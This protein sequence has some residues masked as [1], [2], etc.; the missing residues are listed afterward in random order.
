MPF[1][2]A[3][4]VFSSTPALQPAFQ[5]LSLRDA[6]LLILVCCL[7]LSAFAPALPFRLAQLVIFVLFLVVRSQF[8]LYPNRDV[9]SP[10]QLFASAAEFDCHAPI[11]FSF[12]APVLLQS[13]S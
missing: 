5:P 13:L 8:A 10:V 12:Q 6:N 2:F 7:V 4:S 1:P 9:S 3:S 11:A